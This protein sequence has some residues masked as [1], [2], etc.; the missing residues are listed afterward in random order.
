[1]NGESDLFEF[2]L[3]YFKEVAGLNLDDKTIIAV[4]IILLLNTCLF[5]YVLTSV[6]LARPL[7]IK[8]KDGTTVLKPY[9]STYGKNMFAYFMAY[10]AKLR[11]RK[12]SGKMSLKQLEAFHKPDL[13]KFWNESYYFNGS[14]SGT[15]NRFISRISRHGLN[16]KE[17]YIV[18]ALDLNGY[19]VLTLE[20][21]HVS[22]SGETSNAEMPP[23]NDHYIFENPS[24]LNL[25]YTCV[26]PMKK[27]RIEYKGMLLEGYNNPHGDDKTN[28]TGKRYVEIDLMYT[29]NSDVFWYM[30]DE[31]QMTLAKNLSEEPWG[32]RFFKYCLERS[33]NHCHIE[34]FGTYIICIYAS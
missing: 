20:Q 5:F 26:D 25:S 12:K 7:P 30:R 1:M 24:G 33:H 2:Y 23:S 19:G 13:H 10:V 4:L 11:E 32:Y 31:N 16:A 28:S 18:L 34:A 27:W 3:L 17:M 14:E 22:L 21:D 6:F 29:N 8:S 15:N 9:G